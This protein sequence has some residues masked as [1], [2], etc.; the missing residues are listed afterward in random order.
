MTYEREESFQGDAQCPGHDMSGM[1]ALCADAPMFGEIAEF[2][3][4]R[5]PGAPYHI[6]RDALRGDPTYA[7]SWHDNLAVAAQDEGVERDTANRIASRFMKAAFDVRTRHP[8]DRRACGGKDACEAEPQ[9]SR[10][11]AV[12]IRTE[13][14]THV[15]WVT[16]ERPVFT[17]PTPTPRDPKVR[18]FSV[19]YANTCRPGDRVREEHTAV[20]YE[21]LS[22]RI[23]HSRNWCVKKVPDAD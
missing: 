9:I 1:C 3:A 8:D 7:D 15:G 12:Q 23:S 4:R 2:L 5:S 21:H 19:T 13:T 22:G 16:G 11:D 10:G 18:R 20:F 17:D 6:F 14:G